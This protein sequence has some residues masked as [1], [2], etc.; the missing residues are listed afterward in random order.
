MEATALLEDWVQKLAGQVRQEVERLSPEELNWQP[1]AEANSI[2]VTIWHFSRWLDL[3]KVRAL[4]NRPPSEEQWFTRGWSERTGY[5]PRGLGYAGLGA[6]TGYTPEEV[7]RVP[8]L[9]GA[10]VLSYLD[11]VSGALREH[12]SRLPE[13]ALGRAALG[14]DGRRTAY[15][16]I[17]SI[18][19]GCFGHLGEIEALKAMY[20]RRLKQIPSGLEV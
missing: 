19:M 3:L 8:Q 9:S 11:Q 1:D 13:E 6:L 2:G 5:D 4:E 18:L 17:T 15:D 14:F 16:W 10:E 12:L 7:R 20:Q